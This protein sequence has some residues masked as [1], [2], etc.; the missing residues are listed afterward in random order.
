MSSTLRCTRDVG[1]IQCLH[2]F[3]IV[4]GCWKSMWKN[5]VQVSIRKRL[6]WF[7]QISPWE[8]CLNAEPLLSIKKLAEMLRKCMCIFDVIKDRCHKLQG[9]DLYS[10]WLHSCAA[11]LQCVCTACWIVAVIEV[12]LHLGL[13]LGLMMQART[14]LLLCGDWKWKYPVDVLPWIPLLLRLH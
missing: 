5:P 12:H 14:V 9:V 3:V 1:M 7:R 13:G 6:P 10:C 8:I 2:C 4:V 11:V